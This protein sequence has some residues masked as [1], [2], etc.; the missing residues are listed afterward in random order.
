MSF[1]TQKLETSDLQGLESSVAAEPRIEPHRLDHLYG[2]AGHP[3]AKL[4][5]A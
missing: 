5:G 2:T 3:A 4:R 1:R